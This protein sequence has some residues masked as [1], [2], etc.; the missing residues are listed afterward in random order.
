MRSNAFIVNMKKEKEKKPFKFP[1]GVKTSIIITVFGL[2]VVEVAM[3]FFSL[4]SA[5]TNREN[6]FNNASNLSATVSKT[7]DIP[8]F[9]YLKGEVKPLV[10]NSSTHPTSDEWGS[11]EWEIYMAQFA[12]ITETSEFTAM[13]TFLANVA[14][15]NSDVSSV[16]VSYVDT[17]NKLCV[18]LCDS[19]TPE[20]MCPPGCLDTLYEVNYDVL[21]N[22]K[23]GFPPY[24]TNT[25]EY[26]YLVTAGTP[27]MDGDEVVGY[28]FVDVS[29]N[30]IRSKQ[31]DNIVRL[32]LYLLATVVGL[33]VIG[34]IIIHFILVKPLKRITYTADSYSSDDSEST[35]QRFN[36]LGVNTHDELVVLANSLKKMEN[37]VHEKINELTN[38]NRELIEAQEETKKMSLLANKDALTGVKN[39][40]AYD[41]AVEELDKEIKVNKETKFGL[42]MI[43]LNDLKL[44]N[45]EFGHD[46]GNISLIKLADL[47]C[48]S[49]KHSIVYR[50]G[51]DEFVAILKDEDF[52]NSSKIIEDFR[53]KIYEISKDEGL[54][55]PERISAA[56]GYAE[57]DKKNDY[58][59]D[60]TFKR[61][62]K[63]MYLN[64]HEMKTNCR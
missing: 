28:A 54:S 18:Y 12:Y 7:I 41:N 2:I 8:T 17:T 55:V 43:D 50:V 10:D 58:S 45:D 35:H 29:M 44:I 62:D 38:K 27:I 24:I 21:T 60:D 53:K 30:L 20:E 63:N 42:V 5:R 36:D 49:F 9:N 1:I 31:A 15:S 16:Y 33:I 3:V 57:Y 19:P 51:G 40:I 14:S 47:I 25:A 64:K 23:R 26:G 46:S 48:N 34:V 56:I 39:K 32:F 13:H 52:K 6:Y 11:E 22:P 61:A 4:V 59:V 37:D